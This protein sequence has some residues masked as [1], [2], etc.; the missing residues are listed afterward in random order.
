M[1]LESHVSLVEEI[2]WLL[3]GK[4]VLPN[5]MEQGLPFGRHRLNYLVRQDSSYGIVSQ[6]CNSSEWLFGR[7]GQSY[8][9]YRRM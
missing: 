8:R 1:S 5:T 4:I 2:V 6:H 7:A 9:S 3:G